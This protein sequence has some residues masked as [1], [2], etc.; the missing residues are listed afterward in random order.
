MQE[1]ANLTVLIVD[2]NGGMRASLQNMLNQ[3]GITRVESAVNASTAIKQLAKR[4]YDIILCEYDLGGPQGDGQDGQQLLEDLRHHRLITASTIFIMLTS[5]GVYDKVVSAAEL[6]PTDY[7]LK[8]FTVD[9]LS[10]RIKRALERR[11]ALLP[12]WQLA[13]QGKPVDAIR[14]CTTA[15]LASPRYALDFLRLKAELHVSVGEHAQAGSIYR[16]VLAERPL[17]WAGLGLAR[18]MVAQGQIEEA[19]DTLEQLVQANPRLMAA[20]D[21]L[22]RCHEKLGATQ[23]A[24]KVLEDAV[25]ISPHMVRR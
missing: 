10:T 9:M 1:N 8:P 21:L 14:A 12:V 23:D 16:D 18:T 24:Q 3:A 25:S 22:A 11:T 19:R 20:Y 4:S 6:T 2:P 7:V 15:A 5:E 13:A 17:G